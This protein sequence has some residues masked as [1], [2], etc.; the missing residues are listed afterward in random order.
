M[1]S[2]WHSFNMR[3]KYVLKEYGF[4]A[5]STMKSAQTNF[6]LLDIKEREFNKDLLKWFKDM[7]EGK[8]TP[9][10]FLVATKEAREGGGGSI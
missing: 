2:W 5:V 4:V 1:V 8:R 10:I 6:S 3:W 9:G 7:E